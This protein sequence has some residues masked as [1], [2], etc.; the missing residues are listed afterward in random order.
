[1]QLGLGLNNNSP[2][3]QLT[4]HYSSVSRR[5]V[6]G[7]FRRQDRCVGIICI[8]GRSVGAVEWFNS[9]SEPR[10]NAWQDGVGNIIE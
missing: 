3:T 5:A 10:S 8:T 6:A 9:M 7:V 1:M 2:S 4:Y